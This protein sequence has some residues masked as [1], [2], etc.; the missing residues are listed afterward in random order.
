MRKHLPLFTAIALVFSILSA[1]GQSLFEN[2]TH[3][4]QTVFV[5]S[6]AEDPSGHLLVMG[7]TTNGGGPFGGGVDK[8]VLMKH[9]AD[10]TLLWTK[11]YNSDAEDGAYHISLAASGD[12]YALAGYVM[13]NGTN[14]RDG[15]LLVTDTAGTV[16]HSIRADHTGSNAYHSVSPTPDGWVLAGRSDGGAGGSYD[17]QLTHLQSDGTPVFSRTYGGSEWDWAYWAEAYADGFI[18]AGYGDSFGG[19]FSDPIL[20]RTDGAGD[21]VWA[22]TISTPTAEDGMYC[23]SDSQGNIYFSGYSLGLI[24]GD[25][26]IKGFVAKINASGELQWCKAVSNWSSIPS[27]CITPDDR[28]NLVGDATDLPDGLGGQD[29]GLVRLSSEGEPLGGYLYGSP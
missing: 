15:L 14:S 16:L 21:V 2:I 7:E 1:S 26:N 8:I 13:G 23:T 25:P 27:I 4:N 17:L 18:V 22:R 24:S 5:K 19:G 28:V 9:K 20:I 11:Y 10:G 6:V 3:F 29:I 12:H